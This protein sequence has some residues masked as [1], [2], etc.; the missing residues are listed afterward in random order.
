MT[1]WNKGNIPS[2]A[3]KIAVVTGT[4]GLGYETALALAAE[5]AQVVLAG[6][7]ANKGNVSVRSIRQEVPAA[8]I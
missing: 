2:Q 5:G 3:R 6:R 8:L 7:N 4:G 1:N